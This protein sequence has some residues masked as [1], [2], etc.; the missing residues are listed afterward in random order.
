MGDTKFPLWNFN[1]IK[2]STQNVSVASRDLNVQ[3]Q[4]SHVHQQRVEQR[5]RLDICKKLDMILAQG[6]ENILH[7][8]LSDELG[9]EPTLFHPGML[10]HSKRQSSKTAL[11]E[12]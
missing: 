7:R 4:V 5:E 12:L 9:R 2:Y 6:S 1:G 8:V 10:F 11:N 3:E